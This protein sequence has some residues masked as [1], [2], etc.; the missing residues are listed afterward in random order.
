MCAPAQDN[1]LTFDDLAR[2]AEQWAKENLDE[3]AL[4]VL[5]NAD[6]EKIKKLFQDIRKEFHG[7]YV[8]DLAALKDTARA[9][10]PLLESY[11]ETVPYAAWLKGQ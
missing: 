5:Q 3:N 10:L 11:E 7:E 4:R 2:S 6:Q 1:T 8:L 9:V